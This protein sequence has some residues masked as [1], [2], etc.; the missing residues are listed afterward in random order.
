MR[1]IIKEIQN[2]N[3]VSKDLELD[4]KLIRAD[5]RA[6]VLEII[7]E[8]LPYFKALILEKIKTLN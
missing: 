8:E 5:E 3:T 6:R 7:E 4:E 2:D 1:N